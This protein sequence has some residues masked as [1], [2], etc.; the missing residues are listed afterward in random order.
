LHITIYDEQAE[1]S[2]VTTTTARSWHAAAERSP[3][4]QL[5]SNGGGALGV[6]AAEER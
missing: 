3:I 2:Q 4:N 1:Q 5:R 6:T